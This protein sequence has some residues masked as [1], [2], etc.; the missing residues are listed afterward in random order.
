V[1]QAVVT[2]G[3]EDLDV[4]SRVVAES[5]FDLPPSRWLIADPAVRREIFPGYFRLILEQVM[6]VGEVQ[7]TEDRTAAALWIPSDGSPSDGGT[8]D[9]DAE[10]GGLPDYPARLAELTG[11]FADRFRAF[12]ETLDKSH[13]AGTPHRHLAILAVRPDCQGQGTGTAM[14]RSYHGGLDAAGGPAAYLEAVSPR[15]RAVYL[16]HG[17]ADHGPPIQFPDDGPQMYPMWREPP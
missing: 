4:L 3:R 13:P 5:F 9:G 8:S 14:L 17:Y 6:A 16:R 12:D 2:A 11:P 1:T 15:T 7:T 10:A